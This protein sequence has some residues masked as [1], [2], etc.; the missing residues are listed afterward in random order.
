MV[1]WLAWLFIHVMFLIGF[2]NR[3][4]GRLSNGHGRFS[5]TIDGARLITGPILRE[6]DGTRA[7]NMH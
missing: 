7:K 6:P 3:F 4:S 1:A 2:R 5:P